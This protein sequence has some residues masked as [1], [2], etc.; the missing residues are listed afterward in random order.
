MKDAQG[1]WESRR[2]PDGGPGGSFGNGGPKTSW[3][4]K[5]RSRKALTRARTIHFILGNGGLAVYPI[6]L[7]NQSSLLQ[8]PLSREF[9]GN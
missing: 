7:T 4:V 9:F 2:F 8:H 1:W 6:E 5:S 3:L